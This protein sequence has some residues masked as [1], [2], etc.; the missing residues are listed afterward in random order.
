MDTEVQAGTGTAE[1]KWRLKRIL[2]QQNTLI[3]F[4]V[5]A[6]G[7]TNVCLTETMPTADRWVNGV[8]G[9]N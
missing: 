3:M 8:L 9:V 1:N 7:N 6:Y 2:P 4:S 5:N